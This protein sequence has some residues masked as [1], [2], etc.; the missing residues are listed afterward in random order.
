[1]N[2][3]L[4]RYSIIGELYITAE[5]KWMIKSII[6]RAFAFVLAV[7]VSV[8]GII[9]GIGEVVYAQVADTTVEIK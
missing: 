4:L 9:P 6:S 8:I 7:S 2:R 1:M 5:E 3:R